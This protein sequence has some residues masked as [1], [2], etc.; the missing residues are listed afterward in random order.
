MR[1]YKSINHAAK[2][3]KTLADKEFG[4]RF[5]FLLK[6]RN[7][8][9][10]ELCERLGLSRTMMYRWTSGSKPMRVN[11]LAYVI[12]IMSLSPSDISY[13]L[14]PYIEDRYERVRQTTTD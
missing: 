10:V 6:V 8:S 1:D 9:Q 13:L 5:K 3:E 11:T 2:S 7:M 12:H 14:E 4:D